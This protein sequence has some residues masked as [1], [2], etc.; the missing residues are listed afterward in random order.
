MKALEIK[1]LTKI[2]GND[3]HALKGIDLNVGRGDFFALLG[4]NG[5]GK[6]T[7]IGI[8]SSLVNK[9]EGTISICGV[10]I[11]DNFP[12]AKSKLGVVN[13]EFNFSQFEKVQDVIMS[14]AGYYGVS[15]HVAAEK[16]EL[17]LK[18]L[19]IWDKKDVFIRE[20]SGGQK[21]R[22]MI[23]KALIH[24]PELLILDEPT[25]GVDIELRRGL[26]DFLKEINKAGTTIILTTHYL[27]EAEN[28]CR[29]IAIIDDGKIIENTSMDHLLQQLEN[30]V[31]TIETDN[32]LPIDLNIQGFKSEIKDTKKFS[33]IIPKDTAMNDLFEDETFKALKITN[34]KNQTNRLEE[35]F[36][37][38]TTKK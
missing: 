16:S 38:L 10:D 36:L 20:L 28:L 11:D 19:G 23:I 9:N 2:Y 27:E 14:Q 25:A 6:S 32:D 15:P 21:R 37:N 22:V 34:I 18:K 33:V 12:L 31:F 7:T 4:P 35:L 8:I 3:V 29:N 5:A 13:Q 30:Q 26:W 24:E 17:Y 1:N